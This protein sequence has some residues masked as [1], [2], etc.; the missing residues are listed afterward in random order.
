MHSSPRFISPKADSSRWFSSAAKSSAAAPITEEFHPGFRAS[1]L[2]HTAR[3][4]ALR[5]RARS[6][7]RKI[8][9]RNSASRPARLRAESERP[10]S[11]FLR[12]SRQNRR[13]HRASLRQRRREVHAIRRVAPQV[14]GV[15]AQLSSITPPSI[16]KP[17]PED[18]WNLLK[19]GRGVR[20]LGKYGTSICCAGAPWLSRILSRNSSTPNCSVP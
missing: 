20:G 14:S 16:D 19:T 9:L 8:R 13:R 6:A 12:R 7:S 15:F 4:V 3:P 11:T 2:A 10:I 1:T 17:S 18:L 5:R